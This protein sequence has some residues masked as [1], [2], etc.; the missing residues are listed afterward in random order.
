[1]SGKYTSTIQDLLTL[2]VSRRRKTS[3][4]LWYGPTG[5]AIARF[6]RI[7]NERTSNGAL[8]TFK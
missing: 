5:G 1:M 2:H 3:M 4:L 7:S 8:Q 6:H